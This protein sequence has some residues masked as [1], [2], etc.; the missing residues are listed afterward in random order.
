MIR[1]PIFITNILWS[2]LD[3]R[4]KS[5]KVVLESSDDRV[6]F[7]SDE[8][9]M[10]WLDPDEEQWCWFTTEK[11]NIVEDAEGNLWM[12]ADGKLYK[13]AIGE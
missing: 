7:Q 6:W 5:P 1:S 4:W 13:N 11:S 9:G 8:N 3:Y 2:G 12:I 10:V